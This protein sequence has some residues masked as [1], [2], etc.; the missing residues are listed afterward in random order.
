MKK[1]LVMLLAVVMIFGLAASALAANSLE[2][3]IAQAPAGAR[4]F[5]ADGVSNNGLNGPV[6]LWWDYHPATQTGDVWMLVASDNAGKIGTAAQ[7]GGQTGIIIDGVEKKNANNT[8]YTLI[9]FEGVWLTGDE[10]FDVS[11]NSDGAFKGGQWISGNLRDYFPQLVNVTYFDPD[12]ARL[13]ADTL[14]GG[15]DTTVWS[16]NAKTGYK[17]EY[18]IDDQGNTYEA[19]QVITVNEDLNLYAV[20][21]LDTFGYTVEYYYDGVIDNSKTEAF[22]ALFGAV[23]TDYPNKV[24]SGYRLDKDTTPFAI[25]EN[26]AN[27]VIEVYYVP[28][29][30]IT[31]ILSYTVEYFKDTDNIATDT[32]TEDVW[33]AAP[34]V[35]T[36]QTVDTGKY[37]PLGYKFDHTDPA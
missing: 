5:E 16:W 22:S 27:N 13:G 15:E 36:V 12:G 6:T 28:D 17:F 10:D 20:E 33:V 11:M 23:I 7:L 14:L 37:L 3:L 1:Y 4:E 25:T 8:A 9:K 2:A 24:I 34:Q 29:Y 18:W 26:A 19:G 31:N 35:L 30:T 21:N 32:V